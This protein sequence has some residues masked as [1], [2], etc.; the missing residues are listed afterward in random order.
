MPAGLA[1]DLFSFTFSLT[2]SSFFFFYQIFVSGGAGFR[3]LGQLERGRHGSEGEW[4]WSSLYHPR[5]TAGLDFWTLL[6]FGFRWDIV[7]YTIPKGE[8]WLIGQLGLG[9]V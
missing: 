4:R 2:S 1:N 7:D 6:V 9:T 8:C 3:F 5:G